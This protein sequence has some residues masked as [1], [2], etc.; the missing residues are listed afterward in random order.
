[1]NCF[2]IRELQ[3]VLKNKFFTDLVNS[4]DHKDLLS[5]S[6]IGLRFRQNFNSN[7]DLDMTSFYKYG[8][9]KTNVNKPYST[10]SNKNY[11]KDFSQNFLNNY[12]TYFLGIFNYKN[13]FSLHHY[14]RNF[15]VLMNE[16]CITFTALSIFSLSLF[17]K[18]FNVLSLKSLSL[19]F[20]SLLINFSFFKETLL[21]ISSENNTSITNPS[22]NTSILNINNRRN[23][24]IL[25]NYSEFST[26]Q[27]I[28]RFNNIF[29]NY[30]Y[31]TGN[32][33]GK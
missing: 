30:D 24:E 31:K 10:F 32:Y 22:N 23:I 29:V 18:I 3:S 19:I 14:F 2:N 16:I 7:L 28:N 12:E 8:I 9:H 20:K 15:E 17:S 25:N 27:R 33:L 6:M 13:V 1:M 26:N 5:Q 11:K 21:F 4:H